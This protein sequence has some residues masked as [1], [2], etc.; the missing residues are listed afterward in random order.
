MSPPE[1]GVSADMA[2]VL[3]GIAS[4]VEEPFIINEGEKRQLRLG[5]EW[6]GHDAFHGVIQYVPTPSGVS[7]KPITWFSNNAQAAS[8]SENGIVKGI[9]AGTTT[10]H[11]TYIN[12]GIAIEVI[13]V[14]RKGWAPANSPSQSPK[15]PA[16]PPPGEA[17]EG[18]LPVDEDEAPAEEPADP[19]YSVKPEPAQVTADYFLSDNDRLAILDPGVNGGF[20]RHLFPAIVYG[21]PQTG[22]T[23]VYS[24]GGGGT[25]LITLNGYIIVDGPGADFTIFE[26]PQAL[27]GYQLFAERAQ[28]GV[29]D[30]GTD[31]ED[32]VFFPCDAFDPMFEYA[33]CA[34]V[35]TVNASAN[36][37]DPQVSGGDAFDLHDVKL[38]YAKHIIIRDLGTCRADD[39]TYYAADGSLLCAASGTQGFDLDA[40]AIV[41]GV[42][43]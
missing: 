22:G 30:R 28:V 5:I 7:G 6:E 31:M 34:G 35:R 27:T 43:E 21:R 24:L 15:V 8:V 39:P 33:G 19:G 37:L 32:F 4:E 23:H 25:I 11:A 26:N 2:L 42:N 13:V 36:P 17:A 40:M 29:S 41:N 9:Q 16:D 20:K 3:K 18:T 12:K 14:P 38:A 10:I 1:G